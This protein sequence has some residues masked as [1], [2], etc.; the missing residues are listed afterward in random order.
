MLLNLFNRRQLRQLTD[1]ELVAAFATTPT[2]LVIGEIFKRYGQLAF[3][4]NLKYLKN[5]SDAEDV[6]MQ[7]FESLAVKMTRSDIKNLKNWLYTVCK[8]DC[9]MF[10]RKRKP[11]TEIDKTLIA[12]ANTS[13]DEL[14]AVFE[15]DEKLN[16]LEKAIQL[17]KNEQKIC[18]ELFY[19]HRFCYEEVSSKTG[20]E[21]KKVKS[22][23]QNGKR[24]L[25]MILEEK[26]VFKS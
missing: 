24:N 19:L 2:K 10:L 11:E 23:I 17:L 5:K 20:Y 6:M 3:G 13:Q 9:L 4:V 1:K 25:K 14:E 12:T 18:I 26:D 22:Y 15:K 21:V 16:V 7:T 8:N